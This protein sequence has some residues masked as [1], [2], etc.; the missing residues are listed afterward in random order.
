MS[1]TFLVRNISASYLL[2]AVN[3]L[4]SFILLPI[5][6]HHLG[7]AQFALYTFSL[8]VAILLAALDL[9]LGVAVVRYVAEA[10]ERSDLTRVRRVFSSAFYLLALLGFL[11]WAGVWALAPGAAR[12]FQ[13]GEEEVALLA[14]LL[15]VAT[16]TVPL[17]MP[18][19]AVVAFLQANH[20]LYLAHA[21][22]LVTG[23]LR[24]V[25]LLLVVYQGHGVFVV[26]AVFPAAAALRLAGLLAVTRISSC[27]L[28]PTPRDASL[29][30]LRLLRGFSLL[31][32]FE[33]RAKQLY[34]Q[35]D[36]FI[37]A[38]F[39][40]IAELAIVSV[41]RRFPGVLLEVGN[42]AL[43]VAYPMLAGTETRG[44][45]AARGRFL[46]VS[47][48]NWLFGSLLV[49]L[50]LGYWSETLLRLWVGP[51]VTAGA[52]PLI[53]LLALAVIGG[54]NDIPITSFYAGNRVGFCLRVTAAKTAVG[55][56]L[57]I[58]GSLRFGL[59]GLATGLLAAE[60]L[61]AVV[62]YA[63][64]MRWA[65]VTAG[66]MLR[67]A[68]LPALGPLALA[69]AV[70]AAGGYAVPAGWTSMLASSALATVLASLLF[71][72]GRKAL[73]AGSWRAPLLKVLSE[74]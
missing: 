63:E 12:W 42:R 71:L 36:A 50:C 55:V 44:N 5:L 33:D 68:L 67:G 60:L 30:E 6:F 1:T 26:A 47:A 65:Q 38:R 51:Q 41:I 7:A 57:A 43:A 56:A 45:V 13:F 4:L 62:F 10:R 59:L 69:A 35:S 64:N 53:V 49:A 73:S 16:A 52:A 22:D 2:Y 19:S 21:V 31:S 3:L 74:E 8:T 18:G 24:S 27:R 48:R 46:V 32:F 37:T 28:L 29:H 61:A 9:G 70:L 66:R 54:L 40:G 34:F 11:V 14:P 17:Q 15:V 25:G 72:H 58:A 39:L 23:L 20:D